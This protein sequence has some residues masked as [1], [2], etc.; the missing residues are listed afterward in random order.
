MTASSQAHWYRRACNPSILHSLALA[1]GATQTLP[2]INLA[3]LPH[4]SQGPSSLVGPWT[5]NTWGEGSSLR[6]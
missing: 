3:P 2:T 5:L 6:P 4:L 1:P